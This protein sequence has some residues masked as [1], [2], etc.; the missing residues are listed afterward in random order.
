MFP[1]IFAGHFLMKQV[2]EKGKTREVKFHTPAEQ[3][4]PNLA[5]RMSLPTFTTI[6]G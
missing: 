6:A 3:C 4:L 5:L 2:E 1:A